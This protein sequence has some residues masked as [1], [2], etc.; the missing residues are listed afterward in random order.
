MN[1]EPKIN[2]KGEYVNCAFFENIHCSA[3]KTWYKLI[4]GK[5]CEK[6][7]FFKTENTMA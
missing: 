5:H 3:L 4:A 1:E 7:P 6:C 2:S